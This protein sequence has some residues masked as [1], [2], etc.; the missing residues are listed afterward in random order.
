MEKRLDKEKLVLLLIIL[1]FTFVIT[2]FAFSFR[3]GLSPDSSYHLDISKAY[4][5]T[6]GIPENTTD[7]YQYRDITRIAYLYF[8][9][10][11][12]IL[13]INNEGINEIIL[14]RLVNVVYSIGTVY[15]LY[16][17]SK[18]VIK[19]RWKRLLPVFLLTNTLMF[20]FLSSAINYD[21]LSNLLSVLSIFFFVKFVKSKLDIKYL[22]WMTLFLC[23]GS[24]TKFTV[25]P[26]AGILILLSIVEIFRKRK[27]L[28]DIKFGKEYI[29]LLPILVFGFL[30]IQLYGIN[31]LKYGE[32]EPNCEQI[33]T[34]EQC[35]TNG[36]Y[37]R[38][39]VT[40]KEREINGLSDT[41]KLILSGERVDPVRYFFKWLPNITSKVHGI[42]ADS[43]LYMPESFTHV[44]IFLLSIGVM[45]GVIKWK[46]WSVLD[47]YLIALCIFYIFI[48]FFFQNYS[49]YLRY[50]HL[51]LALQGRYIF[52][53]ITVM[54]ILFSKS[55]LF[56]KNDWLRYLI[57][58]PLIIL[59]IYGCLPFFFTNVDIS[60]F[61]G[62]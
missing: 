9:I 28:K 24:L 15:V 38:D 17:L 29:L 41:V 3:M 27:L 32:L 2:F 48:L 12:R 19:D 37:Y 44:Y 55:I 59:F 60:W 43:S 35:L 16:L 22:L 56:I 14:L 47:K 4:S 54:Y 53:V 40:F 13:N 50:N 46:K 58:I 30:N 52:P 1:I 57:L 11:G 36:V 45:I 34:H 21:N 10:N 33:L 51:Y 25:L 7:T 8:W 23:I 6:L 49:M 61:S 26:L 18:E 5:T 20:V 31:L 62:I 39:T 42:M